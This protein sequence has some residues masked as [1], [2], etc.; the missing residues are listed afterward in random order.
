MGCNVDLLKF[1]SRSLYEPMTAITVT[2]LYYE[3][4]I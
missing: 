4:Y 1:M 2:D 3:K